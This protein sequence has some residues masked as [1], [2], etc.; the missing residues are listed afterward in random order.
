M[1]EQAGGVVSPREGPDAV[2]RRLALAGRLAT[3]LCD[4]T[5]AVWEQRAVG[6]VGSHLGYVSDDVELA[7]VVAE[8]W[9]VTVAG[10][11]VSPDAV[12]ARGGAAGVVVVAHGRTWTMVARSGGPVLILSDRVAGVVRVDRDPECAAE[13]SA[14]V[15]GLS[16]VA[17]G[18][19][20]LDETVWSSMPPLPWHDRP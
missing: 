17:R 6:S 16:N 1:A 7:D 20:A 3:E 13:L 2:G 15:S 11:P 4:L 9:G 12:Q 18:L 8:A 19:P 10:A 14:L 5:P